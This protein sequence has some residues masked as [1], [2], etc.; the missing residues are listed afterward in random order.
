MI[1]RIST[2]NRL[3][4][5]WGS[6]TSR[7]P[8]LAIEGCQFHL[9]PVSHT[10]TSVGVVYVTHS[11]SYVNCSS[12]NT[13]LVASSTCSPLVD[14]F[15]DENLAMQWRTRRQWA[16]YILTFLDFWLSHGSVATYCRWG[17]N[18][19]DMYIENFL[20][21]HLVKGIWKLV[22]ICQSY[23]QIWRGLVFLEHGVYYTGWSK[24]NAIVSIANIR[25]GQIVK[26]NLGAKS[27][28]LSQEDLSLYPKS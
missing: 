18:F 1:P 10:D 15:S 8:G 25:D 28:I 23:Y 4:Q 7:Q 24:R 20:T 13:C 3:L 12:I 22:H 19:C 11:L 16:F 14:W 5:R 6:V 26:S 17:G 27:Q 9:V 2:L 21:N